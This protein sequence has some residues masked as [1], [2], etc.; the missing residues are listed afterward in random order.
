MESTL[1][2]V[3]RKVIG[4][5]CNGVDFSKTHPIIYIPI[6]DNKI[7]VSTN[8]NTLKNADECML[9][10]PYIWENTVPR[11]TGN[12]NVTFINTLR[13]LV[14]ID[15][16]S[17]IQH[18]FYRKDSSLFIDAECWSFGHTV[19]LSLHYLGTKLFSTKHTFPTIEDF[20]DIWNHYQAS[21][22]IMDIMEKDFDDERAELQSKIDELTMKYSNLKKEE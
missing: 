3:A 12:G 6:K 1:I 8:I 5:T 18:F 22:K 20:H 7:K 13:K 15:K 14:H 9:L 2:D 17:D 4:E 10:L 21:K 16:N 11:Y 19:R